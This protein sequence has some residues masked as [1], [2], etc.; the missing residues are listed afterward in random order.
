[1]IGIALASA[2][3]P[4]VQPRT[5]P[6]A[7]GFVD[8]ATEFEK[9]RI[10]GLFELLYLT[11]YTGEPG[12][13]EGQRERWLT[14]MVRSDILVLAEF[15]RRDAETLLRQTGRVPAFE[16]VVICAEI[17]SKI[18]PIEPSAP[19]NPS[20]AW[21]SEV[22]WDKSGCVVVGGSFPCSPDGCESELL[23]ASTE[24][25]G[26]KQTIGFWIESTYPALAADQLIRLHEIGA[27]AAPA[28][29]A[30]IEDAIHRGRAHALKDAD[31]R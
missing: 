27:A 14:A 4:T 18:D 13:T 5:N 20:E 6:T 22:V 24:Y 2:E 23:N 8:A 21:W 26:L 17:W 30:V 16:F 11:A 28:S 10:A 19:L 25:A 9:A 1:M 31:A 15:L 12:P 3:E 29:R 7:A